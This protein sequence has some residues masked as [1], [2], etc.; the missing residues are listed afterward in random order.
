METIYLG[1]G[2]NLGDRSAH[3][4][5]AIQLLNETEGIWIKKVSSLY[6]T[7]PVGGP[8]QGKFLNGAI[9]IQT[10]L[11]PRQ[12]LNSLKEVECQVGRKERKKNWPREIDL[13]IL[14]YGNVKVQEEGLE[15]PHPRMFE[16]DF[17]MIPLSEIAGHL[18][19]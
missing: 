9:K 11:S 13:D 19:I 12:L 7:E 4:Q 2:S 16:R 1:I 15:I 8:P 5:K 6:E 14:L 17:V 18:K 3:I 10:N